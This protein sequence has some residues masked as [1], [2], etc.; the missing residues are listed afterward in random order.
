MPRV[1]QE[2]PTNLPRHV[3]LWART[4]QIPPRGRVRSL[5]PCPLMSVIASGECWQQEQQVNQCSVLFRA[6][7]I[8]LLSSRVP[9]HAETKRKKGASDKFQLAVAV[10][11][12]TLLRT[13]R[14]VPSNTGPY[15]INMRSVNRGSWYCH[16]TART[17]IPTRIKHEYC[18]VIGMPAMHPRSTPL[19]PGVDIICVILPTNLEVTQPPNKHGDE[20]AS[21][22]SRVV[23]ECEFGYSPASSHMQL[24]DMHQGHEGARSQQV[25]P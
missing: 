3:H 13:M 7:L 8:A 18:S 24:F 22:C 5:R 2:L 6:Y 21:V 9:V 12:D 11:N 4:E 16:M 19:L 1:L 10:S 25:T 14:I 20:P 15:S 17:S 23:N